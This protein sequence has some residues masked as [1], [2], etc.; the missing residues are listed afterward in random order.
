MG[1]EEWEK[2][3]IDEQD[4]TQMSPNELENQVR[5]IHDAQEK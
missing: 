4:Y 5:M 3:K 1:S 2:I